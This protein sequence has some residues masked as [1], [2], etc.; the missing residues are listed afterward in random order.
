MSRIIVVDSD[1]SSRAPLRR[2]LEA[3][4]YEVADCTTGNAA[5][6]LFRAGGDAVVVGQAP[7]DMPHLQVLRELRAIDAGVPAIVVSRSSE[8]AI[9]ALRAGAHFSART[10]V[11]VEEVALLANRALETPRSS[12]APKSHLARLDARVDAALVGNTPAM[13]AIKDTIRRLA[14][15]PST[16]V[17][18]TGESGSGKDAVARTI[19]AATAHDAA[20]VYLTPSALREPLLEVELFGIEAGAATDGQA[21]PGLLECAGDGT[22]FL[23]E[24]S[25]MPQSLQGKL[26]RFL[27][28]KTFRR[29]GAV[30]DR[31]SNAR[32]IA[33]TSS[34]VE[35]A[36]KSGVLRPDLVYRLSVVVIE[37]PPLRERRADIPLLVRHFLDGLSQRP[38]Q[39]RARRQSCR[40]PSLVGAS[41]ARQRPGTRQRAR[42]SR[43]RQ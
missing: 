11:N 27:Q 31:T 21:R 25:D 14:G 26:L 42:A 5:R 9:S 8:D 38:G 40:V 19:H 30:S 33:S 29:I 16:T 18:V 41:V 12:R 36:A 35:S 24:I 1:D 4:G 2:R 3:E 20:F 22:L 28:E 43:A 6:E 23:D 37:V 39:G 34:D 7:A 13:R 17:L 15:S 10:P 32:V